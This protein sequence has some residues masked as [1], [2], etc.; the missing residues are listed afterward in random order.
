MTAKKL[1]S[2][3]LDTIWEIGCGVLAGCLPVA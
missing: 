3:V 2:G 1:C